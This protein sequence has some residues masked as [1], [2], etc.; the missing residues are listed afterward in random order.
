VIFLIWL[1]RKYKLIL[2]TGC[3]LGAVYFI[4]TKQILYTQ[5]VKHLNS[6]FA[7][8]FPRNKK[9][10]EVMHVDSDISRTSSKFV[11]FARNNVTQERYKVTS[12]PIE[13]ISF[14]DCL[15]VQGNLSLPQIKTVSAHDETLPLYNFPYREYLAKD[16]VYLLLQAKS[17]E[18]SL[19][20]PHLSQY[21]RVRLF[22]MKQKEKLTQIFLTRYEQP[23]AGLAAGVLVAGKGL[24]DKDSLDMFKRTSLS[25]TVVLSGSNISVIL[26]CIKFF[27]DKLFFW[28]KEKG[29]T[30]EIIQKIIIMLAV[31]AFML[32]TGG[33]APIYRAVASAYCGM[34]L[35]HEKTSQVYA[36][37]VTIFLLTIVSPFQTL[38]DPS[39]HLTCCATYGLILFSKPI[40][41][42][43]RL[44][45]VRK[46]PSW[47]REIISVTLATQV[48]V[49]PYI[50]FMTNSFSSVFLVSNV[51]VLPL[52][53]LVML[54]GCVTL[55]ADILG[56]QF[57]VSLSVYINNIILHV[58]FSVVK[59][60]AHVPYGYIVITKTASVMVLAVYGFILFIFSV[61]TF[62]RS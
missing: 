11:F 48:F 23:Y 30:L 49:F 47:L 7:T 26:V 56:V 57:L 42:W 8:L 17:I 40:D 2:F 20:C 55:C 5:T 52:L 27:V 28:K 18:K 14:G 3:F 4:Y 9:I 46:I 60:L 22:F 61:R 34:I 13:D 43:I 24:L 41:V 25:H 59:V 1:Q 37:T 53:P 32:L 54:F 45:Y 62:T 12:P 38:Y 39:F 33:G 44:S 15:Y 19:G 51:L 6:Q 21:S 58:I 29:L 16:D 50:I 36:L 35:F 10:E 31:W